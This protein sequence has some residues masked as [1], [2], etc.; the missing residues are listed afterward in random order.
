MGICAAAKQ[1]NPVAKLQAFLTDSFN[2]LFSEMK[3]PTYSVEGTWELVWGPAVYQ[4]LGSQM[5]D[6]AIAVCY[7]AQQNIYVVPI[8]ATSPYSPFMIYL[9]DLAAS[10]GSEYIPSNKPPAQSP[11]YFLQPYPQNPNYPTTAGSAGFVTYGNH[12]ALTALLGLTD[13]TTEATIESYLQSLTPGWNSQNPP[14]NGSTLVFCGHS[15]GG[16]LAPL[17]AYYLYPNGTT[18]SGWSN[19]Y[20]FPTAGPT[21]ADAVFANAYNAAYPVMSASAPVPIPIPSNAPPQYQ[22]RYQYWNTN[23]YNARDVVP[24]AWSVNTGAATHWWQQPPN[25]S[26]LGSAFNDVVGD[27]ENAALFWLADTLKNSEVY[28]TVMALQTIAIDYATPQPTDQNP[29]AGVCPYQ[30]INCNPFFLEPPMVYSTVTT[31]WTNAPI[32]A[33][34]D[35]STSILYQHI[36]AYI[37]DGFTVAALFPQSSSPGAVRNNIHPPLMTL[38]NH[39]SAAAKIAMASSAG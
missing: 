18:N 17:L 26:N 24:Q 14:S 6:Q 11:Y 4:S 2:A 39:A 7:N 31:T 30:Q 37:I 23:Q 28:A 15:L 25:L 22:G 12:V 5:V 8:A 32:G 36:D 38:L 10:P 13:P 3:N 19:V 29:N 35:L 21:V 33:M 34:S 20:T 27:N 16:G 1:Q 9:E